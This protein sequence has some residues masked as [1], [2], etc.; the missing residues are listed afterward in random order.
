M[1]FVVNVIDPL[2][3]NSYSKCLLFADHTSVLIIATHSK[4]LHMTA[5]VL[6]HVSIWFI[7]N[8]LSLNIDRACLVTFISMMVHSNLSI[9]IKN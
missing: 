7:A 2:V 1:T 3:I 5:S 6:I 8:E 9:K 4:V